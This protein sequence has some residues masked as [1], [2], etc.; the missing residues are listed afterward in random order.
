MNGLKIPPGWKT[1]LRIL[2]LAILLGGTAWA[3]RNLE[4]DWRALAFAPLLINLCVVAPLILLVAA[5]TL[6]LSARVLGLEIAFPTSV[7]TVA[8]ANVAELLP[9][10]G[11]AIVRGAAL[12][13]AGAGMKDSARIVMITAVLTLAI[14]LGF[15]AL[16]FVALGHPVGW[17]LAAGAFAAAGASAWMLFGQA[18]ARLT[19]ALIGVRLLTLALSIWALWLSF[20]ALGHGAGVLEAAMLSVS[21]VL[22]SAASIVPAGLGINEAIAAGLATLIETSAAAAFLAVALNRVTGLAAGAALT[23]IMALWPKP[24]H[25]EP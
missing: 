1:P 25:A 4:L 7:A 5:V 17:I 12:V 15:S 24:K 2:G 11:G 18:G 20:R 21:A 22:G 3:W 14:T 13:Q 23:A 10:P 8:H 6:R 9:I 19:L 16:A